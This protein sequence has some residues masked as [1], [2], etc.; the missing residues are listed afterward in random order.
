MKEKKARV[1]DARHATNVATNKH[2]D[3][4]LAGVIDPTK[5]VRVALQNAASVAALMLTTEVLIAERPKGARAGERLTTWAEWGCS[6]PGTCIWNSG[7]VS[8]RASSIQSVV[9]PLLQQ[10]SPPKEHAD[11]HRS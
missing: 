7:G 8:W 5:A 6:R 4:V 2:E 1:E 11:D 10:P 3:L 9:R